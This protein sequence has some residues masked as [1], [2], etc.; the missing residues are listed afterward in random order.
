VSFT[1]RPLDTQNIVLRTSYAQLFTGGAS[2]ELF[3][4]GN[5]GYFLFNLILAY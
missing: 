5:P 3:N 4:T 2:K 1:Y